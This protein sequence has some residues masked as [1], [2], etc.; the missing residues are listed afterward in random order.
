[1]VGRKHFAPRVTRK[2]LNFHRE[3]F[4]NLD[5]K[6]LGKLVKPKGKFQ[7]T[8]GTQGQP[9]SLGKLGPKGQKENGNMGNWENGSKGPK[10]NWDHGSLT[11]KLGFYL[12]NLFKRALG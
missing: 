12:E 8:R 11:S 7:G 4:Q 9:G 2:P 10:G 6:P 5:W 1:V 3:I